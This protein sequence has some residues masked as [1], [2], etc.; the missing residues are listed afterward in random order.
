MTASAVL[1][2][3]LARSFAGFS[4]VQIGATTVGVSELNLTEQA[5]T[6]VPAGERWLYRN[7][8]ALQLVRNGIDDLRHGRVKN[9][10]SFAKY[11]ADDA[12]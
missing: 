3:T 6:N 12:E 7:K 11:A 2:K 5:L 10:G 1:A 8:V 4:S 9:R